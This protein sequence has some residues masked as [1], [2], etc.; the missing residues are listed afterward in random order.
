MPID[1]NYARENGKAK[2]RGMSRGEVIEKSYAI[3]LSVLQSEVYK[4][5]KSVMLYMPIGSEVLTSLIRADA[6]ECGKTVFYP[7]TDEKTGEIS[8]YSVTDKTEFKK[9]GFSIPEPQ[10]ALV[11]DPAEIELVIVPGVAFSRSGD[12][13]GFG[14]GCYDRFLKKTQAKRIGICYEAQLL[15]EIAADEND[16][17]MDYI[18]TENGIVNIN[19]K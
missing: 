11:T 16:E 4:N 5:A 19:G 1:K 6:E 9:G 2:R 10:N 8:A 12:R 18:V 15:D 13:V 14:K 7:V 17:R 3:S